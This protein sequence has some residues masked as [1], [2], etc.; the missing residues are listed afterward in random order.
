MFIC[1]VILKHPGFHTVGGLLPPTQTSHQNYFNMQQHLRYKFSGAPEAILEDLNSKPFLRHTRVSFRK[2]IKGVKCEFEKLWGATYKVIVVCILA[3]KF[4]TPFNQSPPP[5]PK[6][7]PTYPHTPRINVLPHDQ[8]FLLT[9]RNSVWTCECPHT[10][11][12]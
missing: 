11:L 2:F 10:S 6:W 9:N 5:P 12:F 1:R 7:N 8:F 4:Q 3:N